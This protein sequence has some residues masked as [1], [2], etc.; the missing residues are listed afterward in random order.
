VDIRIFGDKG[1]LLLDVERERVEVRRHD[2]Q[3]QSLDV[4]ARAGDYDCDTPPSRF[5]EIIQ[6]HGLNESP[7]EVAARSVELIDAMYRS[8]TAGGQPVAV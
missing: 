3:H 7:G 2:G 6:G 8:A 4:P 1:V 5:I